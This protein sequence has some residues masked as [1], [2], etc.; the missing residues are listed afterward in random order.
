MILLPH[1]FTLLLSRAGSQLI[2]HNLYSWAIWAPSRTNLRPRPTST[3]QILRGMK[4]I[5]TCGLESLTFSKVI[6][7]FTI[8]QSGQR[9]RHY[10]YWHHSKGI[11]G[12]EG[13]ANTLSWPAQKF[14]AL[15]PQWLAHYLLQCCHLITTR[16]GFSL[17]NCG[18]TAI[19]LFKQKK[20]SCKWADNQCIVS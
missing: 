9:A 16:G 6:D 2:S 19:S 18:D 7:T 20:N 5:C 11:R 10:G 12:N 8:V 14:R 1:L 4:G 13:S 3:T 17:G 15:L